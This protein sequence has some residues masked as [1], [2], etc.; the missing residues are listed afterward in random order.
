MGDTAGIKTEPE[1]GLGALDQILGFHI[2]L[3]HNAVYRHFTETFSDLGLTQKQVSVLWLIED[4]DDIAQTDLGRRLQIDRATIMAIVNRLQSRG[5]VER[6]QSKTD[7]RRQTL[8]IT[9]AGHEALHK[10]WD[11]N[12]VHEEWLKSKF[13]SEEVAV[14]IDFLRRIHD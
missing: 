3:A 2:R 4:S 5:Y 7:G 1:E 10:A 11:A 9:A 12:R 14:L 6:S 8:H 13:T